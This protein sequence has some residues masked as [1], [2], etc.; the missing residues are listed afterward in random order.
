MAN[1]TE[2]FRH[3]RAH[4]DGPV[5]VLAPHPVGGSPKVARI[6]PPPRYLRQDRPP[7][8]RPQRAIPAK[9]SKGEALRHWLDRCR[10]QDAEVRAMLTP[11]ASMLRSLAA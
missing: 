11:N 6:P 9:Q 1:M 3:H 8:W 5:V 7:P 10:R 4:R 2:H